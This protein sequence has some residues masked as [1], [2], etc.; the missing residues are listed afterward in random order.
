[1]EIMNVKMNNEWVYCLFFFRRKERKVNN[2]KVDK[3][4][5]HVAWELVTKKNRKRTQN[6]NGGTIFFFSKL[7]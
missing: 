6:K 4:N 5:T 2:A 3:Q 1:M 7:E